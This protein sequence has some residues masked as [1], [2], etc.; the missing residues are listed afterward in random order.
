MN[1][2][3]LLAT[4]RSVPPPTPEVEARGRARLGAAIAGTTP[5]A[6][7][8]HLRARHGGRWWQLVVSGTLA[9]GLAAGI[10]VIT[11]GPSDAD[12]PTQPPGAAADLLRDASP[13]DVLHD[14]A[15]VAAATERTVR[16]DQFI[17]VSYLRTATTTEGPASTPANGPSAGQPEQDTGGARTW[18]VD[19]RQEMWESADAD[20]DGLLRLSYS[21]P[22]PLPGQSLPPGARRFADIE[23]RTAA[24]TPDMRA[25]SYAY[26]RGLP[27]DPARLRALVDEEVRRTSLPEDLADPVRRG[28]TTW[29]MLTSLARAPAAPEEL[30]ATVYTLMAEQAGVRLVPGA[31]D[32]AG[33][34]GVAVG[35]DLPTYGTRVELVFDPR[36]HRYLGSRTVTTAAAPSPGYPSG[37][38]VESDALLRTEVVDAPPPAGPRVEPTDCGDNKPKGK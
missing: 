26:L 7:P 27:A 15:L 37:T 33:R 21:A 14:A 19:S 13:A 24:C 32:A 34:T 2:L 29:E 31:T 30:R 17:H 16:N 10:A 5:A 36:T 1:E 11:L 25:P 18:L 8:Q 20:A 4:L 22:R 6:R 38:V 3:D 35:R 28:E 12:V 23:A 9:G